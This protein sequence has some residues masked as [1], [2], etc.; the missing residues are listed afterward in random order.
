MEL[1]EIGAGGG[2]LV[3]NAEYLRSTV[4]EHHQS[5]GMRRDQPGSGG[6]TCVCSTD[7]LRGQSSGGTPVMARSVQLAMP[8]RSRASR[9]AILAS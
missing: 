2:E 1:A 3:R 6:K 9:T 5:V 8:A 7:H 4:R